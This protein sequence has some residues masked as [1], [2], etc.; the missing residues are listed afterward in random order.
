MKT[1]VIEVKGPVFCKI[2]HAHPIETKIAFIRKKYWKFTYTKQSRTDNLK[3]LLILIENAT[4]RKHFGSLTVTFCERLK[5]F[6]TFCFLLSPYSVTCTCFPVPTI[7]NLDLIAICERFINSKSQCPRN[8][9]SFE[10]CTFL[11]FDRPFSISRLRFCSISADLSQT[12]KRLFAQKKWSPWFQ[13]NTTLFAFHAL[14][15]VQHRAE[16]K[17]S[18]IHSIIH[19]LQASEFPASPLCAFLH[20]ERLLIVYFH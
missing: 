4:G 13:P 11:C 12:S 16:S 10:F 7:G 15:I 6:K 8:E 14:I 20:Q 5:F 2:S 18:V 1:K 17:T 19:C 9:V 3:L